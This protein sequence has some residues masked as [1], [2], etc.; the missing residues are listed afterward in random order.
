MKSNEFGW[1]D[2]VKV[3]PDAVRK[4]SDLGLTVGSVD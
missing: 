1:H 4:E 3:V 2:M